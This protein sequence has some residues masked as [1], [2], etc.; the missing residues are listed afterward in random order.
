MEVD[1]KQLFSGSQLPPV[2]LPLDYSLHTRHRT[3]A[4]K[5]IKGMLLTIIIIIISYNF[6]CFQ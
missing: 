6:F 4:P 5:Q 1:E 3:V 2:Q